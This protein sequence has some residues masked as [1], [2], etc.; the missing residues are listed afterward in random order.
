M[1]V[2]AT[3]TTSSISEYATRTVVLSDRGNTRLDMSP[4]PARY[5]RIENATAASKSIEDRVNEGT[6]LR[7]VRVA[8]QTSCRADQ[9]DHRRQS[10][11]RGQEVRG[12]GR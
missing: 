3:T 9:Y 10:E 8:A 5:T 4:N 2:P 6:P 1:S 12:D 11:Q 7:L